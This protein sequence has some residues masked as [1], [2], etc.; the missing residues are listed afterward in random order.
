MIQVHFC[1]SLGTLGTAPTGRLDAKFVF[2]FVSFLLHAV[3]QFIVWLLCGD[4]YF[5]V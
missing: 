4:L 3:I 1:K 5:R 2:C